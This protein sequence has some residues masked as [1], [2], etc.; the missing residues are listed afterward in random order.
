MGT[1]RPGSTPSLPAVDLAP[2]VEQPMDARTPHPRS[3]RPTGPGLTVRRSADALAVFGELDLLTGPRLDRVLRWLEAG[4][5]L[6]GLDLRDVSFVDCAG[7]RPVV[8][9]ALRRRRH[10]LPAAQCDHRRHRCAA[11]CPHEG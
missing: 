2:L 10:H 3:D 4:G 9:A 1:V 6:P 11:C 7:W 5:D 8:D